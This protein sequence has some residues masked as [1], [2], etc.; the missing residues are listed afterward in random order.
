MKPG[1]ASPVVSLSLMDISLQNF[2]YA[3]GI[4]QTAIVGGR[5]PMNVNIATSS[6]DGLYIRGILQSGEQ[7][8]IT[9]WGCEQ[10]VSSIAT[11]IAA[12]GVAAIPLSLRPA[13]GIQFLQHT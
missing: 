11:S 4:P 2:A 6:I 9:C 12:R 8:W 10:D 1:D 3:M 5:L 7:S 13:S